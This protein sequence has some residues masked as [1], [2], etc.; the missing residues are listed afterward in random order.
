[1][2]RIANFAALGVMAAASG[3]T[4]FDISPAIARTG[5]A[6]WCATVN[7]GYGDV[8]ETC[9]FATIEACRPFVIAGNRGFCNENPGY[10]E[11]AAHQ[12][13]KK[14]HVKG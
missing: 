3:A 13:R 4:L 14:R 10:I 9:E 7:V 11:P 2:R 1:M 5:T 8:V 12:T 6:R